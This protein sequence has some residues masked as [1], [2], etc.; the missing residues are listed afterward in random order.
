[1]FYSLQNKMFN[2]G[3]HK[4]QHTQYIHCGFWNHF[5]LPLWLWVWLQTSI[6]SIQYLYNILNIYSIYSL[7]LLKP[8]QIC[9]CDCGCE[10]KQ[11]LTGLQ[12]Y[13]GFELLLKYFFQVLFTFLHRHYRKVFLLFV[14]CNIITYYDH[15]SIIITLIAVSWNE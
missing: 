15:I 10:C 13:W 1:M 12:Y 11:S 9:H 4:L 3:R 2:C 14:C 8:L 5:R 6:D 7:C